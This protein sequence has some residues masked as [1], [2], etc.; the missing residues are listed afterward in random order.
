MRKRQQSS[1]PQLKIPATHGDPAK[2]FSAR[3]LHDFHS[4]SVYCQ[5]RFVFSIIAKQI[6]GPFLKPPILIA[7]SLPPVSPSTSKFL[8]NSAAKKRKKGRKKI[9]GREPRMKRDGEKGYRKGGNR[10]RRMDRYESQ[11]LCQGCFGDYESNEMR[12]H[13]AAARPSTPS[14]SNH[15]G[16]TFEPKKT[17]VI[18]Q[19]IPNVDKSFLNEL[20]SYFPKLRKP[21]RL[22]SSSTAISM[23]KLQ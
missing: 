13:S 17:P 16:E 6:L 9:R 21:E 10:R 19:Q 20:E 2:G 12:E 15:P 18:K 1:M 3:L 23:K 14:D 8:S 5:Q 4:P 7:L 22:D 11:P